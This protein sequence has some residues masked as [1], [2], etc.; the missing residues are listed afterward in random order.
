MPD[1]PFESPLG[2][3]GLV[4]SPEAVDV[5]PLSAGGA[6]GT[7]ESLRRQRTFLALLVL[8]SVLSLIAIVPSLFAGWFGH[9]DPRDCDLASSGLGPTTGH[10]FGFDI[11]GC[12]LYANVIY[13]ARPSLAIGLLVTG[14]STAI[15]IVFGL[16]SGF[17]GGVLDSILGRVTD[18]FYGF[19][20]VVG[21]IVF[22]TVIDRHNIL[23]VSLALAVFSWPLTARVMRSAVVSTTNLDFITAA[24]AMRA[25]N[26]RIMVRHVL[27]N[28]IAPVV[29]VAALN[30]GAVIASEA[31]LTFLG[32]GLQPPDI[33]WGLQLSTA[34]SYFAQ[35]PHLLIF[36]ALFLSTTVF[37]FLL[38]G[39]LVASALDPKAR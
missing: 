36:P 1:S 23:T 22:L 7:W 37:C 6:G 20:F 13:G 15:A 32:V 30:F 24:R 11:Q 8:A 25:S 4:V 12:D 34:Q 26:A 28:S 29:V 3:G 35:S 2:G 19:P 27:P 18:V 16:L 38:I 10:P 33:S 9:G 14:V 39:E 5:S 21:A 31:A 17:Y